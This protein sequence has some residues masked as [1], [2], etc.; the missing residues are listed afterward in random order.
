VADPRDVIEGRARWCVVQGDALGVLAAMPDGCVDA[1][2]TDP[3]AGIG[4]M[5]KLWDK[6]GVLGVSG[7]MAMPATTSSRNPSC[8]ACGGRKRSGPST[9]ACACADPDWNDLDYRLNDRRMFVDWLSSI[10]REA[11]RVAKP[12]AHALVW[13]L[14][15]TSHWTATAIEDAGW[16]VRDCCTHLFGSGFP[17]S[18]DVSKAIDRDAGA[19]REVVGTNPNVVRSRA[20]LGSTQ[21]LRTGD[22]FSGDAAITAPSSPEA[23]R[24]SGWGTA[25]KPAAEFWYLARK[26][27]A[28]TIAQTVLAH[29]TGALNV[30]GCRV[31]TSPGDAEAME[32]V[33]TPGS[34]RFK[35][36]EWADGGWPA[37]S[38]PLDT[39]KGRWPPNVLLSHA[40]GCERIGE[41]K[42]AA[43][44]PPCSTGSDTTAN[45]YGAFAARSQVSHRG[46]DGTETV[47]AW[48]CAPGCPV[49][50]IDAQSGALTS[51]VPCGTRNA[52]SGFATGITPAAVAS[53]FFPTFR[54]VAKPSRQEREAG[55]RE[56][57]VGS[58]GGSGEAASDPV[59]QR[60]T[61]SARNT[62]P[63]SKAPDLMAWLCRL[64]TP[65]GGVVLDPFTG[66]G[67]TGVAAMREGFRF[68]GSERE[69]EYVEIACARIAHAARQELLPGVV[70]A[71]PA[72]AVEPDRQ[73][74]LFG[75][76][77]DAR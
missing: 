4:F 5:G 34:G 72:P 12:G 11:L 56:A 3:P 38:S 24:W 20:S 57:V 45:A 47:E 22:S 2:V 7:G 61:K 33:N 13:A 50:E 17:K 8:R 26:P 53:R 25:L 49:A 63:T 60:F 70:V 41:R 68:V 23:Q 58:L 1:I 16:E 30:D 77:A 51:G 10:L 59:S 67:S 76:A 28:G 18:H 35:A 39:T 55:L 40:E 74:S 66:S 71:R 43:N 31:G 6:P 19:A 65:P 36:E 73:P 29:G 42:I 75:E 44:G 32:R 27:L 21:T 15:R 69:A 9:K 14:P 48:A 62:H 37:A 52:S 64:V 46:A 54:Y